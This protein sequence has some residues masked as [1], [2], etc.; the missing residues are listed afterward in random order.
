MST[1]TSGQMSP[2]IGILG[3]FSY[4]PEERG[5]T[6]EGTNSVASQVKRIEVRYI[7]L[8]KQ[9]H[10]VEGYE[11]IE[12]YKDEAERLRADLDGLLTQLIDQNEET[13][14]TVQPELI[15]DYRTLKGHIAE[16]KDENEALYKQ[17]L[18]LR[19]ET[20]SSAQR[21][22]LFRTKIERLERTVGVARFTD[23]QN[24][25]HLDMNGT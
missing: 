11:A 15:E 13:L 3:Q 18:S 19:K 5:L 1:L 24:S 4:K 20:Q 9:D 2:R 25:H 7:Y 12:A 8:D 16:Q 6:D 21:I 10:L 23:D 22:A 17:L 14:L